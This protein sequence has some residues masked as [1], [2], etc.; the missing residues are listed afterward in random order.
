MRCEKRRG[1][2]RRVGCERGRTMRVQTGLIFTDIEELLLIIFKRV[3]V[4]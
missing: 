1:R 2:G 3:L 4:W